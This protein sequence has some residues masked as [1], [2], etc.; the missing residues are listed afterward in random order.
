MK[1]NPLHSTTYFYTPEVY[2][3]ASLPEVTVVFKTLTM[4]EI[5]SLNTLY[6]QKKNSEYLYRTCEFAIIRIEGINREQLDL[7]ALP[8][9]LVREIA[10]E[11]IKVSSF[12]GDDLQEVSECLDV[13][14][15][16]TLASDTWK[17]DIC[18]KKR[19]DRTRNCGFL[20]EENKDKNFKL[21]VGSTLFTHCPVFS[22]DQNIISVAIEAYNIYKSGFLPN[23][24][25][26]FD[27]TQTFSYLSI[28]TNNKFET[29][30]QKEMEKQIKS[31]KR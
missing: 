14:L 2:S 13:Y 17:C 8:S 7:S 12:S 16:D 23:P 26:W 5:N 21:L 9:D 15:S 10:S 24:G 6:D 30:K 11:I 3:K 31:S 25:G 22:L 27:Q 18:R 1:L 29:K 19:L 28:L 4:G 20:G